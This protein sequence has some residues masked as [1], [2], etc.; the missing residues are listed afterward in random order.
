MDPETKGSAVDPAAIERMLSEMKALLEMIAAIGPNGRLSN[1]ERAKLARLAEQPSDHLQQ[2]Q[3][4]VKN[5][6]ESI[7]FVRLCIKYV[8][9]DLEATRRENQHLR[10]MLDE[11]DQNSSPDGS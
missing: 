1:D 3:L 10:R 5:L 7:A 4:T 9:F 8:V 2:V 11:N 6:A